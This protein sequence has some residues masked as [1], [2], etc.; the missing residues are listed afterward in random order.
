MSDSEPFVVTRAGDEIT[1]RLSP[2]TDGSYAWIDALHHD[3][4]GARRAFRYL[5]QKAAATYPPGDLKGIKVMA[6][7]EKH[8]KMLDHV[9]DTVIDQVFPLER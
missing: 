3:W 9:K 7:V 6:S 1:I 4:E 2:G 8:L 5:A